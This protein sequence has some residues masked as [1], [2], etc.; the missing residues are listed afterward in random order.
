MPPVLPSPRLVC[1]VCLLA[2]AL[3][4]AQETP[5]PPADPAPAPATPTGS[6][7]KSEAPPGEAAPNQV[8]IVGT[9]V[10]RTPGSAHFVRRQQL[11]RF[12]YDDPQAAL[13]GVPGVYSRGEDGVGLRPNIGVRGVNP[14]RSKKV[15]LL[16]DGIPV[17]PAPYSASAAYYFPLMARMVGVRVIKGPA[18]IGYGPQTVGGA[19]D[20]VTR[21]VPSSPSGEL[22]LATGQYGY[23]KVHGFV[24]SGDEKMG[25]LIEGVHLRSDGFK[26]LPSGADT[27]F[28]RNEWMFKGYYVLDPEAA[29]RHE[30]RL[31]ATYSDELSNETY[32]GLSDEDFR[33]NPLR[34]YAAT[35]LDRMR[36]FRTSVAASHVLTTPGG[37]TVTT[38]AYRSDLSRVWR[39]VNGF[40]GASV[41]EVLRA[42]SNPSNAVYA[43]LL[44]GEGDS[45]TPQETLLIGP[46]Q[47]DLVAQGVESRVRLDLTT[48]AL[49]HRLEY[50]I[51]LHQDRIER[52]HSED[53]FRLVSGQLVPEGSPTVVTA[54]NEATTDALSLHAID[55]VTWKKLT[56]TA[57]LRVEALRSTFVDRAGGVEE[58]NQAQLLLP[59]VG[60]YQGLTRDLGVLGGVYRGF[61][62]PT[63]GSGRGV[64]PELSVNYEGGM[65]WSRRQSR[66]E[67]I[68]FY[69]DYQNLTDVCTLSS[70]CVEANLDRQF[71][72]GKARIYGLEAYAEHAPRVGGVTLPLQAA[73][74]LTRA[75]FRSSFRS[76]DPIFGA[77]VAGDQMPYVPRH[78][79]NAS[80]GVEHRRAGASVA[81]TYVSRMRE[82][83]GR[84]PLAE[85]LATDAQLLFDVSAYVRLLDNVQL[86]GHVRNLFDERYLV[87]RRPYGARSNAPRWV[88]IGAKF[89]F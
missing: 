45:S 47:R 58:S 37:V 1:F 8:T 48:G 57:G 83:A 82:I 12:R 59:G 64:A 44:R 9:S 13:A 27:G 29:F 88:Q 81:M 26:E 33:K 89:S 51:R 46:N 6:A 31:K 5:A 17:A 19:I 42:P 72:A 77:V 39:K 7:S 74:T 24:G 18:A 56:V 38:T 2:P 85:T 25:A 28:Y 14:D 73:Y 61:S 53:G 34:R 16:E 22:E 21:E 86:L 3:A 84:E 71:D 66:A 32:V 50:G 67:V 87:S 60:V 4:A 70:G 54:F 15:A 76:D 10:A 62:P 43:A 80:V 20:L 68:G 63:P 69:N 49:A 75:E 23:G 30:L 11:E 78:Q 36:W 79:L 55:A 35:A 40:R 65:R 52:R 41:F